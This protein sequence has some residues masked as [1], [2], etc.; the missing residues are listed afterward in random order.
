MSFS[1][2][3]KS[4]EDGDYLTNKHSLSCEFGFGCD[5]QNISPELNWE[6]IPDGTQSLALTFYNPDAPKGSGF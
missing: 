5:G 6:N 2:K 3:S 4:F 1:L